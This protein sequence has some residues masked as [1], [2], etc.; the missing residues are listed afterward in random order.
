MKKVVKSKHSVYVLMFFGH[1]VSLLLLQNC[2]KKFCFEDQQQE[3]YCFIY[4]YYLS[5]KALQHCYITYKYRLCFQQSSKLSKAEKTKQFPYLYKML[6]IV[7][8]V[9]KNSVPPCCKRIINTA[10]VSTC[11]N[12]LREMFLNSVY[13]YCCCPDCQYRDC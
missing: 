2:Q 9:L 7:Q 13:I 6:T 11:K 12:A 1:K 3:D 10:E 5:V 4:Y 8:G